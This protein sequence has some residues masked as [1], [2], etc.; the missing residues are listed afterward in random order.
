MKA[1][2]FT[3]A[4]KAVEPTADLRVLMRGVVIEDRVDV[5][6]LRDRGLDGVEEA[7]ELLMA[8]AGHVAADDGSVQ[9]VQRREECR[10]S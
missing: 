9:H 8:M 4:Q 2:K 7:D 6:A 3:D 1:S 10:G 5:P